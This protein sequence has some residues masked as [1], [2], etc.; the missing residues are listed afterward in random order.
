M[1]SHKIRKSL[2]K[3]SKPISILIPTENIDYKN[4]KMGLMPNLIHSLDASNIH[5]LIGNILKLNLEYINLY[6]IHD[7]FAS[8]KHSIAI[9]ELLVKHSFI[10]LYF[11]EDFLSLL[12]ESF[13][14]QISDKTEIHKD[15]ETQGLSIPYILVERYTKNGTL[16]Y[17]KVELPQLPAFSWDINEDKLKA[18]ILYNTYFIS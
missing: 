16:K 9:I 6:T 5:L 13:L 11:K 12:S 4:L 7:C 1:K 18:E 2:I 14:K 3:R 15:E 10:G 8:Y 17:T